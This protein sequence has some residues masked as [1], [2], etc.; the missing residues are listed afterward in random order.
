MDYEPIEHFLNNLWVNTLAVGLV[1]GA[2][3]TLT[4]ATLPGKLMAIAQATYRETVRQPIYWIMVVLFTL[5]LLVQV[6]LPYFTLGE[7][8]KMLKNLQ[9]DTIMLPMLLI[10][11]LTAAISISEEIEGR[12]AVTLLSKPVSRRQFLL[13][14]FLGISFASLLMG[15]MLALFMAWTIHYKYDFDAG[16]TDRP[17]EPAEVTQAA[18]ALDFLPGAVVSI[19]KY[20]LMMLHELRVML[21]GVVMVFGQVLILTAI[22]VALATRLPLLVNLVTCG[23]LFIMGRLSHVLKETSEGNRLVNFVAQLIE[24]LLPGFNYYDVGPALSGD[25]PVPWLQY[26]FPALMHGFIY[27]TIALLVG[28]LLFEDRDVA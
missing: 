1:L 20:L 15:T 24:T 8:L 13:G 4:R 9:L 19:V 22:A 16:W 14:K 11:V 10:S 21:P 6:W 2:L 5:V 7:D 27:V 12:T 17:P 23:S 28:L 18:R 26:V 3:I 25:V